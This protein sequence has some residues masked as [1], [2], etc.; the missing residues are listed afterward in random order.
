MKKIFTVLIA[1]MLLAFTQCKPDNGDGEKVR[2]RC[3][4]PVGNGTRSDFCDLLSN[5][6]IYWSTGMERVYLA[7]PNDV[8]PQLVELTVNNSEP[9]ANV[10]EFEGEV[11]KNLLE[12]GKDYEVWYFGNSKNL[13]TPYIAETKE[14]NVIRGING[15]IKTQSGYQDDLGYCHIAKTTVRAKDNGTEID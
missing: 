8:N 9:Q 12:D 4:I 14:G 1:L 6:S 10:L 7:I 11:D 15:S 3:N 13:G 2:V 5:D